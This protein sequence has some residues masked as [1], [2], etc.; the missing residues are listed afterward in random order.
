MK[1]EK[2]KGRRGEKEEV[3]K[4]KGGLKANRKRRKVMEREREGHINRS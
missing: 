2:S 4:E 3:M 1:E